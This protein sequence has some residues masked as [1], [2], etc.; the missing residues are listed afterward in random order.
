[1]PGD[2]VAVPDTRNFQA[3][4]GGPDSGVKAVRC[5]AVRPVPGLESGHAGKFRIQ[6]HFRPASAS[7]FGGRSMP[8]SYCLRPVQ[9]PRAFFTYSPFLLHLFAGYK[10][11]DIWHQRRHKL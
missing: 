10:L 7:C 11:G 2:W 4:W 6:C 3:L 5:S 8:P 9:F 1:M